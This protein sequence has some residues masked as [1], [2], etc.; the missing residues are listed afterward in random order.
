MKRITAVF[1]LLLCLIVSARADEMPRRLVHLWIPKEAFGSTEA[2]IR[3]KPDVLRVTQCALYPWDEDET[4]YSLFIEVENTS[5]E[6]IVMNEGTLSACDANGSIL[7][8]VDGFLIPRKLSSSPEKWRF[9]T[10]AQS[11]ILWK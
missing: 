6:A 8:E 1:V 4:R 11:R 10:Q 5:N 2:V 3:V 7:R 9:S